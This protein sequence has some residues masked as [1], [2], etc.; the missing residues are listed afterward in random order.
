[1]TDK[2]RNRRWKLRHAM[3]NFQH[4]FLFLRRLSHERKFAMRVSMS[5]T[6][7]ALWTGVNVRIAY[8]S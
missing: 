4:N 7:M 2:R 3:S 1:M 5:T 6:R 8:G